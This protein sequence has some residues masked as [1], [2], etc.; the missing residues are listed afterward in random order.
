VLTLALT[1]GHGPAKKYL[2]NI[3]QTS[4]QYFLLPQQTQLPKYQNPI[5]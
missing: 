4:G 3:N 1:V 2:G 5:R